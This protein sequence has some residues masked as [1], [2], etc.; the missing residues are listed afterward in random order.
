[1]VAVRLTCALLVGCLSTSAIAEERSATFG[2]SMRVVRSLRTAGPVSP[3][4]AFVGTVQAAA[5]PCGSPRSPA[6]EIAADEALAS[7]ASRRPVILT[8]LA[9]GSPTSIVER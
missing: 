8:I 7:S 1:M 4:V 6:C 2:V 9:D 3:L 5:L